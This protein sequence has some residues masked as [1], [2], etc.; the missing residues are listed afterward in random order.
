MQELTIKN[1]IGSDFIYG[2]CKCPA[3]E[4]E[5]LSLVQ[6]DRSK[7][8]EKEHTS[9]I[10]N[11][12]SIEIDKLAERIQAEE[13]DAATETERELT[14]YLNK[15]LHNWS[16]S[17]FN[18]FLVE[19]YGGKEE[20]SGFGGFG[21]DGFGRK[22][23]GGKARRNEDPQENKSQGGA[24]DIKIKKPRFP[25]VLLSGI[26]VDPISG[27][28]FFLDP[29]QD[30][31]YQRKED[32]ENHIWWINTQKPFA[33]KILN[34]EGPQSV[35]WKDYLFQRYVNI[36]INYVIEEKWKIEHS[37]EPVVIQ[38][39]ILETLNNIYESAYKDLESYLFE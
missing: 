6:N 12:I 37:I 11:W 4:K 28:P 34:E 8:I 36:I 30:I 7:L 22:H 16:K 26:D 27:K 5:E 38:Q 25:Q 39:W 19:I 18:K 31:I 15:I 29:R 35:K 33:V 14:S 1:R 2:E 23:L 24:G 20:G 10:L 21:E 9:A 13:C 17:F 3:L 32:V